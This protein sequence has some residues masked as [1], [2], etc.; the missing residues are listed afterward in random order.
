MAFPIILDAKPGIDHRLFE[1]VW[2]LLINHVFIF[3]IA[4]RHAIHKAADDLALAQQTGRLQVIK[5]RQVGQRLKTEMVKK[6][7][8]GAPCQRSPGRATA[9]ARL[10][11]AKF[12]QDV[13]GATR[14]ADAADFLDLC[15]GDWLVI[16]DD[17]KLNRRLKR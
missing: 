7:G 9:A 1:K 4:D 6:G 2:P 17:G 12:K 5:A 13:D 11:P 16:G 15:P 8:A 14:Q 3:V 10:D